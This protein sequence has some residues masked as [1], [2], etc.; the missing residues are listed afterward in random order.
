MTA[1]DFTAYAQRLASDSNARFM[2]PVIEKE[3]LHYEIIRAMTEFN[4]LK[5]L[6]FQ[7]GTCLRLSY[8]APR[9]SEDLDF[10]GG[11]DFSAKNLSE[12]EA[13]IAQTLPNRYSVTA[14]V[15]EPKDDASLVKKWSIRINT[16]PQRS[17]LPAQKISLEV[18]S[19]P[20]HTKLPKMLQLN[21]KGLP[22]SYE[23]II[24]FAESPE[25]ILADKMEAFVCS[26]HIRYRDIWDMYWIM[27][28]PNINLQEAQ[29]LRK[30]KEID[31][32]EQD[33]FK[34]GLIRVTKQLGSIVNGQEF[35]TQ[36]KRF[37][38]ADLH[39][40]TVSREEFRTL[41]TTGIQELYTLH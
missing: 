22:S 19:V 20:A 41:L 26:D 18:A 23:D 15:K 4:L 9:Y 30:K 29:V 16:T 31:Y 2:L 8:G 7:G 17:D 28:R 33:K 27:R 10:V 37:L 38:P 14:R 5:N 35:N 24:L 40:K 6:V 36:M 32:N 12:L 11:S 13:C 25:E 3:L 1:L 34:E 39:E 21:F